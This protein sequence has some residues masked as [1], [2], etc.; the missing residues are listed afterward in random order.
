MDTYPLFFSILA[1]WLLTRPSKSTAELWMSVL[2]IGITTHLKIYP[3]VLFILIGWKYGWKSLVPILVINL[4]LLFSTGFTN[5]G[6][7]IHTISSYTTA[8]FIWVGNHSAA[9]FATYVNN[10]LGERLG[11]QI[12]GLVF[13]LVP[14][15]FWGV[16]FFY[17]VAE[18]IITGQPGLA[19]LAH[20]PVDER[21]PY[22]QLRL[23]AGLTNPGHRHAA[24][25]GVNCIKQRPDA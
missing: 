4:G 16:G 13:Y 18:R 24:V 14:L 20:C 2:L 23:Q 11:V 17:S 22:R 7:F 21:Y 1:L 9:S 6:Q 12:P 15:T 10:Y 25:L 19:V 5:V 3:A 8:P